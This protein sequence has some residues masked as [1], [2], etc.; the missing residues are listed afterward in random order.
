[1]LKSFNLKKIVTF[2]LS[3]SIILTSIFLYS[4][5]FTLSASLILFI[6][7]LNEGHD[8]FTDHILP[9]IGE[10]DDLT[11]V[12]LIIRALKKPIKF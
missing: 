8:Y 3:I 1:M 2:F 7:L 9:K 4:N 10:K 6:L 5:V 12:Y 11:L